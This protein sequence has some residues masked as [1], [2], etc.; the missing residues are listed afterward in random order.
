MSQGMEKDTPQLTRKTVNTSHWALWEAPNLVNG[1]IEEWL[2]NSDKRVKS[3][4]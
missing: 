2:K 3:S 4:L 1:I